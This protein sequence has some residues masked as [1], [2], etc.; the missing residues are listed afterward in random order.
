MCLQ[1]FPGIVDFAL[2][3][4]GLYSSTQVRSVKISPQLPI[5]LVTS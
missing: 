1:D 3:A 4:R 2:L 5:S